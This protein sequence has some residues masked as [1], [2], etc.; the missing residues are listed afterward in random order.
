MDRRGRLTARTLCALWLATLAVALLPA[1]SADAEVKRFALLVAS[2]HGAPHE[3]PLRYAEPDL[4]AV[5]DTLTGFAGFASERVVRLPG[6]SAQRVRDALLD[7]NLAVQREARAG[8]EVLL[9][10]YYSGHADAQSLHLGGTDLPTDELSKL[11]RGSHA[12]LK[13]LLLDACRSGAL[14]QVKGGRQVAPFRIGLEAELR[15]EGY[16]I[17]TSSAAGEDAQESDALRSSVFTYHFLAALKGPGDTNGDRIVTLGEAYGY[18]Y[19]QSLKTS[20]STIVG[21]QHATFDYDMSGRTDPALTDLRARGERAELLVSEPGEYLFLGASSGAL[22]LEATIRTARTPVLLP[23]GRYL[24]RRRTRTHMYRAEVALQAGA[25]TELRRHEL[26][27]EPLAQV[28]RKGETEARLA[29]GPIVAGMLHGPLGDGFS[30]MLGLGVGWAFEL[31]RLTLMPRLHVGRSDARTPAGIT[32]H[33]LGELDLELSALHAFDLGRLTLAPLVSVGWVL[34][35]QTIRG[36]DRRTI[37]STRPSGF[38]TT[39]G[40]RAMVGLGRGFAIEG[41]IELANFYLRRQQA[42][43]EVQTGARLAG[44]L[45]YRATLGLGYRY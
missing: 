5:A 37:A 7:L 4:H 22:I 9:F 36:E 25:S 45:T 16:A 41:G 14:T 40:G 24:V 19:E 28:V 11:V 21:A 23:A 10:V 43:S 29:S 20:L 35:D 30:P 3:A 6:A 18:A 13:I 31:P 2:N 15:S 39:L 34:F 38:V 27:A 17:I 44:S 1:R 26:A 32:A 33:E 8:H 42:T 12:K